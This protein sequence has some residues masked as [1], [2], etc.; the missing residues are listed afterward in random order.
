MRGGGE[1]PRERN[2]YEKVRKNRTQ[3]IEGTET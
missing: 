3:V 2:T 1:S